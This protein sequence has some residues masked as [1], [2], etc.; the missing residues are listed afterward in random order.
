MK[1]ITSPLVPVALLAAAIGCALESPSDELEF[2]E[3]ADPQ[4]F[5]VQHGGIL[6]E[7][8][9]PAV[10]LL[11][12]DIVGYGP[13]IYRVGGPAPELETLA[14]LEAIPYLETGDNLLVH[15]ELGPV[16]SRLLGLDPEGEL[17]VVGASEDEADA[18]GGSMSSEAALSI[19]GLDPAGLYQASQSCIWACE[20][21]A[22]NC[23]MG[24]G[25]SWCCLAHQAACSARC[26]VTLGATVPQ[27][28]GQQ[29]AQ[30]CGGGPGGGPG[31]PGGGEQGGD[32]ACQGTA[33]VSGLSVVIVQEDGSEMT[34]SYDGAIVQMEDETGACVWVMDGGTLSN[35]TTLTTGGPGEGGE[36][37]T[38]PEWF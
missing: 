29:W 1:A 9:G 14:N 8:P 34:C 10:E 23:T 13:Q 15:T 26:G 19:V 17:I 24:G 38:E 18:V 30:I 3:A 16:H 22:F 5:I 32:S 4:D 20:M 6:D 27:G 33:T 12:G 25:S 37:E 2:R 35:C 11:P 31:V 21:E 28:I 36:G 7:G